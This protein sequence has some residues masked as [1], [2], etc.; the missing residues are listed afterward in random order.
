MFQGQMISK[1]LLVSSN[2]PQKR[3]N[4]FVFTAMTSLFVC[5]LG[6]FEDTKNSFR[7]YLT[8]SVYPFFKQFAEK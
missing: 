3:M 6:E 1:G 8:F 4:E 7:N 5:F 2:F